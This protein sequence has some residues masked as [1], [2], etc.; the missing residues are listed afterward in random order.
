MFHDS[1]EFFDMYRSR[2]RD[3]ASGDSGRR[4]AAATA[5]RL[6]RKGPVDSLQRRG[7]PQPRLLGRLLTAS[8]HLL[9]SAGERFSAAGAASCRVVSRG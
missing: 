5:M 9:I 3:A 8:G 4:S 6:R 7:Q 1:L 2:H